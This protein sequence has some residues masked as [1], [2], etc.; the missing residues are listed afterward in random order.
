MLFTFPVSVFC[1]PCPLARLPLVLPLPYVGV[2]FSL[3]CCIS[4]FATGIAAAS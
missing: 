2:T 4:T 1:P 3:V